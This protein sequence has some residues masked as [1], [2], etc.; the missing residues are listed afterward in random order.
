MQENYRNNYKPN[1]FERKVIA[2]RNRKYKKW[3]H[4]NLIKNSNSIGTTA[5]LTSKKINRI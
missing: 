4:E 2:H 5:N 3:Y 1:W